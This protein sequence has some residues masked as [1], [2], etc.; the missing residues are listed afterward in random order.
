MADGQG[1]D[2]MPPWHAPVALRM[3]I[4]AVQA[5]LSPRS[6]SHASGNSSP[7]QRWCSIPKTDV[8]LARPYKRLRISR[9]IKLSRMD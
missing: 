8:G 6:P 1:G 5:M 9:S 3:S 2:V 4:N 7:A